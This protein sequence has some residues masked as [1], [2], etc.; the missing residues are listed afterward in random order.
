VYWIC[1]I[2]DFNQLA[3]HYS[4]ENT[5]KHSMLTDMQKGKT[6]LTHKNK[7]SLK[8]A[9]VKTSLGTAFHQ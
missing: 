5:T 1:E 4:P 9:E 2:F 8:V 6:R 3:I 7:S